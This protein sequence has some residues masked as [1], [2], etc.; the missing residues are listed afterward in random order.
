MNKTLIYKTLEKSWKKWEWRYRSHGSFNDHNFI[1]VFEKITETFNEEK[2]RLSNFVDV[3][4]RS[5]FRA[6]HKKNKIKPI[7]CDFRHI[8][9]DLLSDDG[10]FHHNMEVN[11]DYNNIIN[12]LKLI[13]P[14]ST[15]ELL[16][17]RFSY[18]ETLGELAKRKNVSTQSIGFKIKKALDKIRKE[19]EREKI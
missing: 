11:Y 3:V 12:K 9:E 5:S 17:K 15:V 2:G 1:K 4:T 13:V 6:E 16:I 7:L 18:G 19:L 14:A 8:E 10:K